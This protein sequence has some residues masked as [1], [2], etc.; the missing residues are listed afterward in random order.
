MKKNTDKNTLTRMLAIRDGE[1]VVRT[2]EKSAFNVE[3]ESNRPKHTTV[4]KRPTGS[5]LIQKDMAT[6]K[7]W[8]CNYKEG[9]QESSAFMLRLGRE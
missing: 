3:V 6:L 1:N 7:K 5:F 9:D 2:T 4:R 8:A